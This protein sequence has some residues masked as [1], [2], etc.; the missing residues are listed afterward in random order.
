MSET[1]LA[2][3]KKK[4]F[5]V[6]RPSSKTTKNRYYE[7]CK[8]NDIPFVAIT[9]NGRHHVCIEMD[10]LPTSWGLS[11]DKSKGVLPENHLK[12][13]HSL[14]D[15]Y[16][17]TR[18]PRKLE[19]DQSITLGNHGGEYTIFMRIRKEDAEIVALSMLEIGKE[20]ASEYKDKRHFTTW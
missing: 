13:L 5:I 11:L 9:P 7:W 16:I 19:E 8:E 15:K 2:Q 6:C 20:W 10:M 4:G 14:F 12:S 3:A 18:P 17:D 1:A